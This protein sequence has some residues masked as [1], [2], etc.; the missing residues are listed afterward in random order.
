MNHVNVTLSETYSACVS[1]SYTQ[2]FSNEQQPRRYLVSTKKK[3]KKKKKTVHSTH[4]LGQRCS[5]TPGF[6]PLGI[7][8]QHTFVCAFCAALNTFHLVSFLCSASKPHTANHTI[9]PHINTNT[10][11]PCCCCTFLSTVLTTAYS[12][13]IACGACHSSSTSFSL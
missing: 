9:T 1:L 4:G 11:I 6:T 7:M 13:S 10:H 12:Y 3:K 2:Y 5:A 8:K